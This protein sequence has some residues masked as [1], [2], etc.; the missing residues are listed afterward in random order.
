VYSIR[1]R[2]TLLL[3]AGFT[4]LLVGT[5]VYV[6][7]LL[8]KRVTE[9]FDAA[10]VTRARA[11]VALTEQEGGQIEFDYAPEFMPEFERRER[12]DYLQ[13]WLD[14][15]RVLFRTARLGSADLPRADA[16]SPEPQVC[17]VP[18]PDGR[19]GR[20]VQIAFVPR[21]PEDADDPDEV[22]DAAAAIDRAV[23]LVVARGRERLDR[24]LASIRW[25]FVFVGAAAIGLAAVFAWRAIVAGLRP[26]EAIASQVEALDAERLT[27]RVRLSQTPRELAPIVEQVN[28][29]LARLEESFERERRFTGNVAH[30]LRTPIAEL[31]S[32]AEVGA[33]WP[34]D[35]AAV[36]RFFGDVTDIAGRMEG[37]VGDLLLLARCQAGVETAVSAPTR[38]KDVIQSTWSKVAPRASVPGLRFH[39]ELPDD[40]V[41]ESDPGKLAI[42]FQNVFGNAASHARPHSEVRCVGT[43]HDSRFLVDVTNAADPLSPADLERLAEPFWRKDQARSR[44]DH[45]GLGLSLVSALA[46]LLRLEVGFAQ[47]RNGLFRVR[48]SGPALAYTGGGGG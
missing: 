7:R 36:A 29:L 6:E 8:E 20:A 37:L 9:E 15:G 44:A 39:L 27:A 31:R 32:L 19:A 42:V 48:L 1:R 5:G 11:L 2:L 12:P 24:L 34:D 16:L 18:L 35:E 43:R 47:E 40:L 10:L 25:A 23:V 17:D 13:F 30:E 3:V 46:R 38:L 22:S 26:V 28:A 33:K 41:V 45:A 14:D 21:G 4:V